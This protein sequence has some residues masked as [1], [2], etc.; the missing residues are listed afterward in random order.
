MPTGRSTT[1]RNISPRYKVDR[2]ITTADDVKIITPRG[3]NFDYNIHMVSPEFYKDNDEPL[4]SIKGFD[5]NVST[6]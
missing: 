5:N 1:R 3:S 2:S 4:E 6:F